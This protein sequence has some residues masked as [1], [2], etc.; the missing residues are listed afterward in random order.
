MADSEPRP[1][2]PLGPIYPAELPDVPGDGRTWF[3][4]LLLA[5]ILLGAVSGLLALLPFGPG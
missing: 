2:N 4:L 5:V 1:N 3:A